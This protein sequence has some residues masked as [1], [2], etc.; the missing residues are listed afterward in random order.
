MSI[1]PFCSWSYFPFVGET[2]IPPVNTKNVLQRVVSDKGGEA[3]LDWE[4][5]MDSLPEETAFK[6]RPE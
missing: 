4:R 2:G 3:G 5:S 1:R 6:L